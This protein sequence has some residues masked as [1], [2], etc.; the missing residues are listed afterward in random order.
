[1]NVDRTTSFEKFF[2]NLIFYCYAQC[3]DIAHAISLFYYSKNDCKT[4][5]KGKLRTSCMVSIL[6]VHLNFLML[7]GKCI[8]YF[9]PS[10]ACNRNLYLV[11][12]RTRN[13]LCVNCLFLRWPALWYSC[14]FLMYV[15]SS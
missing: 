1:M 11:V 4:S 15:D 5:K 8:Q 14:S 2:K 7:F 12:F 10:L 13:F 6:Q 9:L 3:A